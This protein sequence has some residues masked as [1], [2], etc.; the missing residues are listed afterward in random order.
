MGVRS[1]VYVVA[2]VALLASGSSAS[3]GSLPQTSSGARPGPAPLYAPAPAAPQLANSA[4]FSAQPLLVSGTD[5][6][7]GGEYL[8]Q[9][10]L[11]DDRGADI[12]P[13]STPGLNTLSSPPD[14]DLLY[15]IGARYA[16]NAA[17]FVEFRTTVTASDVVYRITLNTVR[18]QDAAVVGIGLDTDCA[19]DEAENWPRQAGISSQGLDEFVTAWGTGGEVTSFGAVAD[20]TAALPAGSVSM[21]TERNQ[22]TIRVP[23]T[24]GGGA[25]DPKPPGQPHETWC[26][27][28]GAGLWDATQ[29]RWKPAPAG[30]NPG[31]DTPASGGSRSAPGVFNLAFRFD[32]QDSVTKMPGG[33]PQTPS[34]TFPGTGA[35]FEFQQSQALAAGSTQK[36]FRATV[37]YAKV[38]TGATEA[39]HPPRR[40]QAR[41]YP[42]AIEPFEGVQAAN[43]TFGGRLQPYLLVVP[44]ALT[45]PPGLTFSLHSLGGNYSQFLEY[46][47]TQLKQFGDERGDLVA[48]PL[49]RSQSGFYQNTSELDF[50]E[51]WADVARNF[52]LD[53]ERV[54]LTG[55]SMGGYG[56]YKLAAEYPDLFATAFTAVGPPSSGSEPTGPLLENLRWVPFLNWA[57]AVDELVPYPGPRAQQDRFTNLGLRSQLWTFPEGE[58]LTLAILDEWGPARDHL[59]MARVKRDP[60]RV[61]Y[62]FQ[63]QNDKPELGLIHDHAY[64][65]SGLRARDA[66]GSNRGRVSARSLA[67]GTGNPTTTAIAAPGAIV[68][69]GNLPDGT[70][71]PSSNPYAAD[72]IAWG[73][74][75]ARPPENR[76][77][78]ELANVA[79]GTVDGTRARLDGAEPLRVKLTGDGTG[80]LRLELP[81]PASTTVVRID[82]G[83]TRAA[84]EVTLDANGATFGVFAEEREYLF[85]PPARTGRDQPVENGPG[86]PGS[87]TP[88]GSPGTGGGVRP[89][90]LAR[91]VRIGPRNIGRLK[92]LSGLT[93]TVRR[94]RPLGRVSSRSRVLRYCVRGPVGKTRVVAVFDARGRLR[95]ATTAAA[96]HAFRGIR[97]GSS[98]RKLKERFGRRLL[99]AG[100]TLRIVRLRGSSFVFTVRDG[101][102]RQVALVDRRLEANRRV[103][104]RYLRRAR[105]S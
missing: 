99:G 56:T 95:V 97:P 1:G 32:E 90:C 102:V 51:V 10:Y 85:S 40:V 80:E 31:A 48:T 101:V 72:G 11:Y 89:S 24:S 71:L 39:A 79:S 58:H 68:P 33:N 105:G 66:T 82:G 61:D 41:I 37:D 9:D 28:A 83:Q 45:G 98:A 7:R 64:W 104:V 34:T 35:W 18:E 50:F 84:P 76:L 16:R 47:P 36:K 78:V 46:S 81:L 52:T 12:R 53:S 14:G 44:P 43:P 70:P 17:D 77:E 86:T 62:V 21:D 94:A 59:G 73:S 63:P 91:R 65:V 67:F 15:P 23:R 19:G 88:G 5:A 29:M 22:M 13:L 27:V 57:Q 96:G 69:G 6:Y 87:I 42:S 38:M 4:P 55:Y 25:L 75:A 74:E 8:Y 30:E 54:A 3:A 103:L 93:A 49:S 26:Q 2:A 92:L 20:T 100:R 60:W